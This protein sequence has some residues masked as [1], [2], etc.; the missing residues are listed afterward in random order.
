MII[1]V[2]ATVEDLIADG[3]AALRKGD[4]AAARGLFQAALTLGPNSTALEGLGFAAYLAMDFDEAID[5]WQQSYAGYRAD[6]NGVGAVRMARMLGYLYG[7]V[8]CERA[9]DVA[10]AE[11]WLKVGE[12]VAAQRNLPA[13][14]AY[15]HLLLCQAARVR[16]AVWSWSRA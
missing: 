11:Q 1:S 3:R 6:G 15:C 7:I 12:A 9:H 2:T 5:L 4:V 10:R 13:V 14:V 16:P 8:A